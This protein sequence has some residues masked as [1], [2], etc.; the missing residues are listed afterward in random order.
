MRSKSLCMCM[1]R[2]YSYDYSIQRVIELYNSSFSIMFSDIGT[3]SNSS[4]EAGILQPLK[5]Y[6]SIERL[7]F[8]LHAE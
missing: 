1:L 7:A 5:M 2:D 8:V 3:S 6:E 4:T